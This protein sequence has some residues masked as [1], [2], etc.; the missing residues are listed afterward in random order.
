MSTLI[1]NVCHFLGAHLCHRLLS[2]GESVIGLYHTDAQLS[3][4]EHAANA[5][6][7]TL[8][9]VDLNNIA[10]VSEAFAKTQP[11]TV[12]HFNHFDSSPAHCASALAQTTNVLEAS[13]QTGVKHC[14]LN[15]SHAVYLPHQYSAMSVSELTEH[16]QS[17]QGATARACEMLAH[18]Y[19]QEHKLPCTLVR[20]FEVYGNGADANS[21][22]MQLLEK[23]KQNDAIDVSSYCQDEMDFTYVD[24]VC[25]A[26]LRLQE[27]PAK[28]NPFWASEGEPVDSSSA[29][30]R[31]YNIGTGIGTDVSALVQTLAE[32]CGEK[33]H[34]IADQLHSETK[35]KQIADVNELV[36]ETAYQPRTLLKDGLKQMLTGS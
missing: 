32:V 8:I 7:L 1:T 36:R 26:L 11:S 5:H 14:L 31:L 13:Q 9:K 17:L 6:H 3:T 22:V 34:V 15:S 24:D 10:Q 35:Q 23:I 2:K 29:P 30:W 18:S 25:N 21:L 20:L 27:H 33:A 28:A 12:F 19:S 16:P 4:F